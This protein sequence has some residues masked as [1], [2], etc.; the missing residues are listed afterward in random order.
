MNTRLLFAAT[1][2]QR[3]YLQLF[4]SPSPSQALHEINQPEV[5]TFEEDDYEYMWTQANTC[6]AIEVFF[7]LVPPN[8][9][10]MFCIVLGRVPFMLLSDRCG[11]RA[12][13][14][15]YVSLIW[16]PEHYVQISIALYCTELAVYRSTMRYFI[17]KKSVKQNW[18]I[19]TIETKNDFCIWGRVL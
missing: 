1:E 9:P 14:T 5:T 12:N 18:S 3:I 2:K 11:D 17:Y 7:P 13:F 8:D 4:E 15:A 19:I 6:H 10:W 16:L